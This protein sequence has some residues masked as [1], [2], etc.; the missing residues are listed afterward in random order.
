MPAKKPAKGKAPAV[1]F[2]AAPPKQRAPRTG[3]K[4]QPLTAT[5][6]DNPENAAKL[7]EIQTKVEAS[8]PAGWKDLSAPKQQTATEEL[9]NRTPTTEFTPGDLARKYS[10]LTRNRST[11]AVDPEAVARSARVK[12][13]QQKYYPSTTVFPGTPATAE[14]QAQPG[15]VMGKTSTPQTEWADARAKYEARKASDE[16]VKAEQTRLASLLPAKDQGGSPSTT[17]SS[18]EPIPTP[19]AQEAFRARTLP[20]LKTQKNLP[21]RNEMSISSNGEVTV[22]PVRKS[23]SGEK[24]SEHTDD[25]PIKTF[26]PN[27][28]NITSDEYRIAGGG[29]GHVVNGQ[30]IAAYTKQ[31]THYK[32]TNNNGV[33]GLAIA[34]T[35][36]HEGTFYR[37]P[38]TGEVVQ[39][40]DKPVEHKYD[41][42]ELHH[43]ELYTKYGQ[44]DAKL[45]LGS[46]ALPARLQIAGT[47][48]SKNWARESIKK[49]IKSSRGG[50]VEGTMKELANNPDS[51]HELFHDHF[52]V[53]PQKE[54]V[55]K[56]FVKAGIYPDIP[57]PNQLEQKKA[58]LLN[59]GIKPQVFTNFQ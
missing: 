45:R 58:K 9:E 59:E 7:R 47:T 29:A 48:D 2:S 50:D 11:G 5:P 34:G 44:E 23:F 31:T 21:H 25:N 28:N 22:K 56:K 4:N 46:A 53:G 35:T 41:A 30:H 38:E 39:T 26:A 10:M 33:A 36:Q 52:V 12:A 17:T 1:E 54:K 18:T 8:L 43:R 49:A 42:V 14:R 24:D 3:T 40:M 16:A 13:Y 15:F 57:T 6:M 27:D 51:I 19:A 20:I 55:Y 37:H 32:R